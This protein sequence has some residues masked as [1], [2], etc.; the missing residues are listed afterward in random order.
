MLMVPW[1]ALG[2]AWLFKK[3]ELLCKNVYEIAD[4]TNS[5][6][7]GVQGK[8]AQAQQ[9]SSEVEY[10]SRRV[11]VTCSW[12]NEIHTDICYLTLVFHMQ[13]S[14]ALLQYIVLVMLCLG[15]LLI[16]NL[17]LLTVYRSSLIQGSLSKL[18]VASFILPLALVI[19]VIVKKQIMNPGFGSICFVGPDVASALFFYPLSIIVC[20][21]TLLHLGTIG[22]M[23]KV[24]L[25]MKIS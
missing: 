12:C 25:K 6:F 19:P 7:C 5:W 18:M 21:A 4:M 13:Q 23:I 3:E 15:F 9:R 14:G 10:L 24:R 11:C 20:V 1:E 17:H 8:Q 16:A 2:T 22:F